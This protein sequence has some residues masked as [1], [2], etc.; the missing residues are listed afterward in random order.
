LSE[1]DAIVFVLDAETAKLDALIAKVQAAVE[2][3]QEYR[4]ALISAAVT[5]RIDV[6]IVAQGD[7]R[8][9]ARRL[10]LCGQNTMK[11]LDLTPT[12]GCTQ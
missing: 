3:L 10:V 5:G 12:R 8:G 4:T 6:R 2:G 1:Q 7:P 11:T 9:A